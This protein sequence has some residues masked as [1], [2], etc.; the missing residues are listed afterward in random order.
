VAAWP[1]GRL[2]QAS[3]VAAIAF[4]TNSVAQDLGSLPGAVQKNAIETQEYYQ[5]QQ[6]LDELPAS[7]SRQD[8]IER[9]SPVGAPQPDGSGQTVFVRSIEVEASAILSPGDVEGITSRYENRTV[10]LAELFS[11]VDQIND[12]Y[13]QRGYITAKAVLPPQKIDD[14]IVRVRLIEARIDRVIVRNNR[15][16]S[17]RFIL[18][19]IDIESGELIRLR[20][21]ESKLVRF[22]LTHDVQLRALLEP[23]SRPETSNCVLKVYEPDKLTAGIFVDNAGTETSGQNRIGVQFVNNSLT[24]RGDRLSLGGSYAAGTD[25]AYAIYSSSINRSG[26]VASLGYDYSRIAIVDGELKDLD[27]T[28]D[29]SIASVTFSHPILADTGRLLYG[30]VAVNAKESQTDF[31]NVDSFKTSVRSLSLGVEYQVSGD[32]YAFYARPRLDIGVE[33]FGGDWNFLVFVAEASGLIN[34]G[35]TDEVVLRFTGQLSDTDQLPSMEQFQLGGVATVRGYQDVVVLGDQ[36]YFVSAAY[37]HA[38][39]LTALQGLIPVER[40][41]LKAS[42]FVD[43]GG[44]FTSASGDALD[45]DEYLNSVGIGLFYAYGRRFFGSLQVGWPLGNHASDDDAVVVHFALN[46][47][48]F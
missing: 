34:V 14:G 40:S 33:R 28:G 9:Q 36:G 15:D 8:L 11:V 35:P 1:R 42:V 31:S 39:P 10:S 26:T 27:V 29:S 25:A 37:R 48:P 32:G 30:S 13:E 45:V 24:G 7:A 4:T 18:E 6:L 38:L 2:G 44:A 21:L 17:E 41:S 20:E 19:R 3:L 46:Y 47:A 12:L 22:N 16:T 23:G 43:H 5:R